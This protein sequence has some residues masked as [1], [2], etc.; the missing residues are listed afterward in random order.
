M[1]IETTER[2]SISG[3]LS[4]IFSATV[5]TDA[6]VGDAGNAGALN[7]TTP[8][9]LVD[10]GVIDST[11]VGDGD[12][13]AIVVRVGSLRLT[14]GA[15]IRSFSGGFDEF[16]GELVVGNGAAGS[17]SVDATGSV[18]T[19]G[20]SASGRPSG[21][22]AETRGAGAGGD[23]SVRASSLT[24]SDGATISS[25]SLGS[26]LAGDVQIELGD[27]LTLR[28]GS[29]ATQATASDGGNI[30]ITAPRLIHLVDSR[31]STSVESG[32]GGG[33]NIFIDPQFVVLQNSQVIANAFGGPGGNINI[34]AGQLI[35]DPAT[36]ISASSS[37][38]IDG[39]VNIEA[40]DT[41]VSADLAVLAASF[42]DAASLMQAGCG[43]AR[44]GLSSLVEVGRGGLPS[45]PDD[46]LASLDLDVAIRTENAGAARLNQSGGA[47]PG[48]SAPVRVA[49]AAAPE[50][51]R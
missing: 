49:F 32:V 19:S 48:L 25:S 47:I 36:A 42:L 26:G 6:D 46:Y 18:T 14:G 38:G 37:L 29:I 30:T 9:L 43:A 24:V 22:L 27:S 39:T 45:A 50:C 10:G 3:D 16:T 21:L 23:V 31:I 33:G 44:A 28:G 12:A 4:G 20:A 1:N 7:I 34:I 40:P 35:A 51:R 5:A 41:D 2:I 13:G 8:L 17:V 11:T 15:Q